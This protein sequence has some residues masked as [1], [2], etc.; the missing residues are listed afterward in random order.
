MPPLCHSKIHPL[1]LTMIS[2][3]FRQALQPA[4]RRTCRADERYGIEAWRPKKVGPPLLP[5]RRERVVERALAGGALFDGDDGA[6]LVDVDQR[7]VEPRAL[8]QELQVAGAVG[9]DI[10]Q[11]HQEEAVSDLDRE[12]PERRAARPLVRF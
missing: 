8:L 9:L 1:S 5:P 3:E 4:S 2:R 11:A 10:R 12:A 6:A 7:H